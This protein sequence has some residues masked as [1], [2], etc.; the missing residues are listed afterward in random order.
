[1]EELAVRSRE[2]DALAADLTAGRQAAASAE[3]GLR[4]L[5]VRLQAAEAD[6][7]LAQRRA[8]QLADQVS[9]LASAL[10]RLGSAQPDAATA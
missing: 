4:E 7:D 1:R 6:R 8:A 5:T 3:A 2:R 9:D 10:A